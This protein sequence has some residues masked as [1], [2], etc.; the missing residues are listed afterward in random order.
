MLKRHEKNSN[1][2]EEKVITLYAKGNST[3]H[4]RDTLADLYGIDVSADT[5]SAN[6]EKVWPLVEAWQSR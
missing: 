6:T 5:I 1:E 3:R 4:I 2:I